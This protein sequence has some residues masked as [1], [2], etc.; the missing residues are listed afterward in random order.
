M[1]ADTTVSTQLKQTSKS[2]ESDSSSGGVSLTNLVSVRDRVDLMNREGNTIGGP[3]AQMDA[4]FSTADLPAL[5]KTLQDEKCAPQ[6]ASAF[7]CICYFETE[8][9]SA[10][11][12]ATFVIGLAVF[13]RVFVL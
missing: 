3:R 7:S 5:Y 2:A 13:G 9:S 8:K 11:N 6:W 10:F 12:F 4:Y 1:M